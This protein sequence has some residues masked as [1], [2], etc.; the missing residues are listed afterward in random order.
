MLLP[1]DTEALRSHGVSQEEKGNQQ[2][3]Q[4]RGSP[5][6]AFISI[7]R[8]DKIQ[9][10]PPPELLIDQAWGRAQRL[11]RGRHRVSHTAVCTPQGSA[12][13]PARTAGP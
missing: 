7:I 2:A 10:A 1:P 6:W 13:Y 4:T 5:G 12:L 11:C 3:L 9:T 8:L